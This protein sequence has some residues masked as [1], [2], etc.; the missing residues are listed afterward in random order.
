MVLHGV[1]FETISHHTV[2]AL[3]APMRNN[4]IAALRGRSLETR[5]HGVLG[6]GGQPAAAACAFAKANIIIVVAAGK[7]E[8]TSERE[9]KGNDKKVFLHF[10]ENKTVAARLPQQRP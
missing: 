7:A 4:D 2:A 8:A 10:K 9:A 1:V 6:R 5:E 3:H